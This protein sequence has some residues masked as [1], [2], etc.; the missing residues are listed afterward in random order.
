M[1]GAG[2]ANTLYFYDLET[3]GFN[4]AEA[5]IMQFAGRRTDMGL[6]PIGEPDNFLLSMTEDTLPDP[7]AILITGITPQHTRAEGITEAEFLRIFQEKIAVPG[8]IF[9]GFNSIRFDDKFMQFLHYR[10]FY[11]PYEWQ[12]QDNRGKWDLLDVVRM[13]RA[14][15]PA[16]IR[17]PYDSEGKPANRLELLAS[18]NKLDHANAHDALSD[19]QATIA[20]AQLIRQKQPKLFDY[21]LKMRGKKEIATLTESGQSFLYTSGKYPGEYEK[22]TVVATLA[23]H[24]K[25]PGVLV[26]DLRQDPTPFLDMTP[27]QLAT[28]WKWQKDPEV[29]R[30]PVKT[31][32]YNHCPAIAPLGVLDEDSKNRLGIDLDLAAK[33][34]KLLSETF[35]SNVLKALETMDKQQQAQFFSGEH[36]VDAQMY[37]GFFGDE[38]K[39]IMRLVQAATPEELSEL[40]DK[41]KDERLKELLPL[42]KARNFPKTLSSE[43]RLAWDNFREARLLGGGE[44]SRL[45]K[46]FA[47]IQELK[48]RPGLTES[49]GFLLEELELYG[50]S[51]VPSAYE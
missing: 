10:N 40:G 48:Q 38:D 51:I 13:T 29:L 43:E 26:Y 47:R 7:D 4:P 22:T 34:Q 1:V 35:V 6:K 41:P 16:G 3:S 5:R 20:L 50:Q 15:R 8:T 25:R 24:P 9:M 42:Y 19:V 39:K 23:K 32:Q 30:L 17:W 37:D 12:W 21:L 28:A 44:K 36:T 27:Q 31:M 11:D 14:L 46:Y 45:A 49:Q 18:I 2:V 33:H